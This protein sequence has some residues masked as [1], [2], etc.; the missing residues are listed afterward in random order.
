MDVIVGLDG[1]GARVRAFIST[2]RCVHLT[3]CILLPTQTNPKKIQVCEAL[4]V[5]LAGVEERSKKARFFLLMD[6]R[7]TWF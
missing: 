7:S 1:P 3:V 6:R 4:K 5:L 2:P